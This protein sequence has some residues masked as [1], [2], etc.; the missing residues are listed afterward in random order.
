M[1]EKEE[2]TNTRP[3][4]R[5]PGAEIPAATLRHWGDLMCL[6]RL[7]ARPACMRAHACRGDAQRCFPRNYPLLPDGVQ[8]WFAGVGEL[9]REG[10]PF[11]EAMEEL[12]TGEEGDAFRDWYA[13]VARSLGEPETP[14][15]IQW[16]R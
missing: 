6:W 3:S 1:M 2:M 7:C 12:D 10:V 5:P 11:D 8:A 14:L 16:W 13:A 4:S 9:Q 15:P